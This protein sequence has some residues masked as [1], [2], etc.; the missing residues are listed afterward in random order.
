MKQ[1]CWSAAFEG[2]ALAVGIVCGILTVF[3]RTEEI[4]QDALL[5]G[6]VCLLIAIYSKIPRGP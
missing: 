4:R 6:I 2:T 1:S 5:Y 3:G